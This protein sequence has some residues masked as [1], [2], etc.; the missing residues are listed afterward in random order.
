[1]QKKLESKGTLYNHFSTTIS[2][3][4]SQEVLLIHVNLVE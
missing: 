3:A 1:M 4:V 2:R